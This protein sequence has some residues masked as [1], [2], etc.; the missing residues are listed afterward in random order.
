VCR[1][2]NGL[3]PV[4]SRGEVALDEGAK[5]DQQLWGPIPYVPGVKQSHLPKVECAS[6]SIT[7]TLLLQDAREKQGM[8]GSQPM[9]HCSRFGNSC[10]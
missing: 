5:R 2:G 6:S 1:R 9:N 4:P 3:W 8:C 7:R 10:N